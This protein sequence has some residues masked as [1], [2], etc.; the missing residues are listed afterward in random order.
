MTLLETRDGWKPQ[1]QLGDGLLPV[2]ESATF[3]YNWYKRG[4]ER[5]EC[6]WEAGHEIRETKYEAS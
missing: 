3:N 4:P 6:V 5:N 1:A 2:M